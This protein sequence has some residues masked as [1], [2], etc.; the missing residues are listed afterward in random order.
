MVNV[1][2]PSVKP[3]R[4]KVKIEEIPVNPAD[5]G[6]GCRKKKTYPKGK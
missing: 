6:D 5:L 1:V 3:M 2:P 4:S